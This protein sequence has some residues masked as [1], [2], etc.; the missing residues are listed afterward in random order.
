MSWVIISLG[1]GLSPVPFQAIT[2]TN[3]GLLSIG[4]LGTNIS[5]IKNQNF[6]GFI[7]E[8]AIEIVIWQ[9][10]DHFVQGEIR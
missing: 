3:A 7:Q 2:W 9:N 4:L 8:N 5:E 10:G 1:N 6:I